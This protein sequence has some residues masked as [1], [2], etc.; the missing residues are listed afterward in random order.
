MTDDLK[1]QGS[2][3]SCKILAS[4]TKMENLRF[5]LHRQTSASKKEDQQEDTPYSSKTITWGLLPTHLFTD[6]VT[7]K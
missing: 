6:T 3:V 2:F 7:N 5:C 4:E 1:Q